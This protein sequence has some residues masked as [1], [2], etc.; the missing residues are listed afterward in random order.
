MQVRYDEGVATH[1][2]S[3]PCV[4][5]R[6]GAGEASAG[7]YTGQPS[8]RDR[9]IV[10][11]A[12][13]VTWWRVRQFGDADG[14]DRQHQ[15][16]IPDDRRESRSDDPHARLGSSCRSCVLGVDRKTGAHIA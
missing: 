11:G 15:R 7:D 4:V 16:G 2:G 10:P 1:I 8:S 3:E 12:D 6:E 14:R 9:E 13:D 5:A